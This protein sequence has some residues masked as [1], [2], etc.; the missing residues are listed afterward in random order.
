[1]MNAFKALSASVAV[2]L[3]TWGCAHAADEA[4]PFTPPANMVQKWAS[5]ADQNVVGRVR[6]IEP[7]KK[8]ERFAPCDADPKVCQLIEQ[9]LL[10]LTLD[11][12]KS[13]D[14]DVMWLVSIPDDQRPKVGYYVQFTLPTTA[15]ELGA[16]AYGKD[17]K[18]IVPKCKWGKVD[19]DKPVEG[20]ICDKWNYQQ[21][22]YFAT[23]GPA[24]AP[25]ASQP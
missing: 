10:V 15:K 7:W 3:T 8:Y 19:L 18:L 11:V 5:L 24:V 4:L 23:P 17:T 9:H 22:P 21:M 12:A 1:M 16:G 6:K 25:A 2:L 20:V 13:P 14:G